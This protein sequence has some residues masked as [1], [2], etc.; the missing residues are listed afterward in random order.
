MS[1]LG[2][3]YELFLRGIIEGALKNFG[4]VNLRVYSRGSL[5][6][7]SRTSTQR[8]SGI[9][10]EAVLKNVVE[11]LHNAGVALIFSRETPLEQRLSGYI[12][13]IE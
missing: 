13:W 4:R 11:P 10:V 1:N 8:W 3:S 7:G 2:I 9:S 5:E 12:F 6:K